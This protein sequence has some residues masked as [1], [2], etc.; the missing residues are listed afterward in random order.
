M[1]SRT[2]RL[3]LI[4]LL[5]P[6]SLSTVYWILELAQQIVRIE[7]SLPH[8]PDSPRILTH[9][10]NLYNE[11]SSPVIDIHVF[12]FEFNDFMTSRMG[13]IQGNRWWE[14]LLGNVSRSFCQATNEAPDS[15][16]VRTRRLA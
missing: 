6:F 5:F 10:T 4:A 8:Q 13:T 12:P 3:L 1:Q 9:Y 16:A 7:A 2:N 11:N 15:L 14:P